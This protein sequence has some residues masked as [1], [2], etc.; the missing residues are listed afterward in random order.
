EGAQVVD[1][2][3]EVRLP[4]AVVAV[5]DVEV[6]ARLEIHRAEVAEPPRGQPFDPEGARGGHGDG[7]HLTTSDRASCRATRPDD[8]PA[9]RGN[10]G[11]YSSVRAWRQPDPSRKRS[12]RRAVRGVLLDAHGHDDAHE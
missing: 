10:A 8:A 11:A 9:N 3:E 12:D 6:R 1:G 4:R 7:T 2:L 5:D